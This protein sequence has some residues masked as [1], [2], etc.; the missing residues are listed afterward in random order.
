VAPEFIG[1][2]LECIWEQSD[3][4]FDL[5][6]GAEMA[7]RQFG[8]DDIDAL[9]LKNEP[10]CVRAAGGLLSYITETQKSDL[11]HINSIDIVSD[12]RYMEQDYM[13][14][15]NLALTENRARRKKEGAFFGCWTRT[16]TP[17]GSWLL[18]AWVER[19][20][21]SPA[22]VRRRLSPCR[23]FILTMCS[24]AS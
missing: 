3:E 22:A 19:P 9:G 24:A 10:D 8:A 5:Q 23:C 20:L 11:K 21:R 13:T 4:R 12:Q 6:K 7:G 15:R 1:K 14:R 16:R 18:R 17:M 2:R